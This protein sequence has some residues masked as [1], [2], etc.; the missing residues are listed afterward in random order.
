MNEAFMFET[1]E[2]YYKENLL[3]FKVG[4][5]SF[6]KMIERILIPIFRA[7]V[8]LYTWNRWINEQNHG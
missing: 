8:H 7:K 3:C 6:K 2:K 1:L 5:I 4:F